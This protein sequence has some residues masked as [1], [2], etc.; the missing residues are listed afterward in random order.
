MR[1]F[2]RTIQRKREKIKHMSKHCPSTWRCLAHGSFTTVSLPGHVRC[3]CERQILS[4]HR[5][6]FDNL[7]IYLLPVQ[8]ILSSF[9]HRILKGG[10]YRGNSSVSGR[11]YGIR[12]RDAIGPQNIWQNGVLQL[13]DPT[14]AEK[15]TWLTT[16]GSRGVMNP[17]LTNRRTKQSSKNSCKLFRRKL[18][19]SC[20]TEGIHLCSPRRKRHLTPPIKVSPS[21]AFPVVTWSHL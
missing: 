18:K 3:V 11:R 20:Q 17:P 13:S 2:I 8:T 16:S 7:Y 6:N 15:T 12:L 19:K 9:Y 21:I 4:Y 10:N 1:N 5:N 14:A